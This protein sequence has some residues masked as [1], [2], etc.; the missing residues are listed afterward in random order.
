MSDEAVGGIL[1]IMAFVLLMTCLISMVK[2][3]KSMLAGSM[4]KAIQKTINADLPGKA[5]F[6]TGYLAM[7]VGC[8]VTI[9]VQSSSVTVSALTP[10]VG[11][12]LVTIDRVFPMLLGANLGTTSTA[13][14]AAFA[15]TG[16]RIEP[17]FQIAMCHLFFNI[18]GIVL[19]YAIP[20]MRKLPLGAAKF[21][22]KTAS[23][24][25][26]FAIV[27]GL[28]LFFII[29][30]FVFALSV[31]GW[32]VLVGVGVPIL[33]VLISIIVI[34]LLQKYQPQ[35]M[36]PTCRTWEWLPLWMRSL[37][38]LDA[39]IT[40]CLIA[41]KC[42]KGKQLLEE[43][44]DVEAVTSH[45]DQP[46]Y[47]LSDLQGATATPPG[48]TP[49]EKEVLPLG[50]ETVIHVNT[51]LDRVFEYRNTH[52]NLA[53]ESDISN[54]KAEDSGID[55]S[56]VDWHQSLSSVPESSWSQPHSSAGSTTGSVDTESSFTRHLASSDQLLQQAASA[57]SSEPP[58][59]AASISGTLERQLSLTRCARSTDQLLKMGAENI[60]ASDIYDESRL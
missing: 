51:L 53:M 54:Q 40:K 50:P 16:D 41:C 58:S 28:G 12:G 10:L 21:I 14:F 13:I 25:R 29:P 33:A 42:K 20:P 18:S 5:G 8:G 23:N 19:W 26:W 2:L 56:P 22:G 3:L 30:G 34:K 6:L 27:Y 35:C 9:L 52:D 31:P 7:L 38:P 37:Q 15:A 49:N 57:P 44:E 32:E 59:S 55:N 60:K 24:Y 48:F 1:L 47:E 39:A 45:Y 36:H 4:S 43:E 17:A 46:Y 11:I